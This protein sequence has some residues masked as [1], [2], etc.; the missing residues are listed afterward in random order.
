MTQPTITLACPEC[1]A[2]LARKRQGRAEVL[3]CT[4]SGCRYKR[5]I[6]VDLVL[7]ALGAPRLPGLD[8]EPHGLPE[9]PEEVVN[10]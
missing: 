2:L 4:R 10:A 7:R 8:D 9:N 1:G 3:A 6:P 5:P